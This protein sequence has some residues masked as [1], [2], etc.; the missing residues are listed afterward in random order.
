MDERRK[1]HKKR[2]G[3]RGNGLVTAIAAVAGILAIYKRIP[4]T[5]RIGDNG[6]AYFGMAYDTYLFFFLF[7]GYSMQAV[8]AK[9]MSAR[10]SRGQYRNSRRVWN[11]AFLFTLIAGLAGTLL[12]LSLSGVLAEG[13]YQTRIAMVVI[14]Y[15]APTILIT[16]L[17]G[18][19]RGYFQGMG[20]VVPT[21]LSRFVEELAG[22]LLM[23]VLS[24]AL[25]NYGQKIGALLLASDY[26][27]AFG[28]AGGILG[29]MAGSAVALLL[30]FILYLMF[31]ASFR[32]K[33]RKDVGKGMDGYRRIARLVASS[34]FPVILIGFAMSGSFFLDQIF[35]FHLLPSSQDTI[36][37]WGI[38]TGKYRILSGIP[39]AMVTAVCT[40]LIP[41]LSVSVASQN[42]GRMKEKAYLTLKLAWTLALPVTVFLAITADTL[43][44]ALF[45]TGDTETAASLLRVG[46]VATVLQ[47][48]CIGLFAALQGLERE[49]NLLIHAVIALVAHVAALCL[50]LA[51]LDQGIRGVVYANIVLYAV[52][53][54]LNLITLFRLISARIDWGRLIGIPVIATAVM[55]VVV[56]FL[57]RLLAGKLSAGILSLLCFA[58]ALILYTLLI[59]ALHG[60]SE[61]ELRGVPGGGG[62]VF[63]GKALRLM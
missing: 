58:A 54:I 8:V 52:F 59:L 60:V 16:S 43:L 4:L 61:R 63:L 27:Q 57:N 44:P 55:G 56:F 25:G 18:L 32:K 17:L 29:F 50:F 21:V 46:S 41:S 20:T 34:A 15:T 45:T 19:M 11:V 7:C 6:N 37:Q 2:P 36:T 42:T 24:Q 23:L 39:I 51:N 26:E 13:L 33:E 47:G 22:L 10:Y 14:Q 38:Y 30:L 12:M 5:N 49:K 53:L 9:M 28:A 35:Y 31:Q 1:V 40:A 62:L 3:R 48:L